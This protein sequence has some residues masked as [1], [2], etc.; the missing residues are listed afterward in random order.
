M[1]R[2]YSEMW[3]TGCKNWWY[4]VLCFRIQSNTS[5]A[6]VSWEKLQSTPCWARSE[7]HG[8][9]HHMLPGASFTE[10]WTVQV[11]HSCTTITQGKTGIKWSTLIVTLLPTGV[12]LGFNTGYMIVCIFTLAV[13]EKRF[14]LTSVNLFCGMLSA[15]FICGLS[16]VWWSLTSSFSWVTH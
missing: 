8:R 10:H 9:A 1:Q 11:S 14:S 15:G 5:T 6:V 7:L 2:W 13:E 3:V 4:T 16:W 12:S